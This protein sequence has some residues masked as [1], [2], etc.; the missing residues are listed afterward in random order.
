LKTSRIP[1]KK[2]VF[3]LVLFAVLGIAIERRVLAG[4][5]SS[6]PGLPEVTVHSLPSFKA[7]FNRDPDAIRIVLLLSPT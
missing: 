6:S 7:E 2:V 5:N 4:D 3:G 1:T